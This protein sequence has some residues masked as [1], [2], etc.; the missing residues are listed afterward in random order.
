MCFKSSF[1]VQSGVLNFFFR[2]DG[3][4]GSTLRRDYSWRLPSNPL[5]IDV[6][7]GTLSDGVESISDSSRR[8]MPSWLAPPADWK[9]RFGSGRFTHAFEW[10]SRKQESGFEGRFLTV[11]QK[12]REDVMASEEVRDVVENVD[13]KMETSYPNNYTHTSKYTLITFV[14]MNLLEQFRRVANSYFL[15][16]FLLTLALP[17]SP[18]SPMS[19]V[20]SLLTVILVTMAKQGYEDMLRHK[21]DRLGRG[22]F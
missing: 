14:P 7:T 3:R 4:P 22:S 6:I 1:F 9:A 16:T 13:K 12:H 8:W 15:L 10:R 11:G 21:S 17:D 19:W 2:R 18:V 5:P 20:M